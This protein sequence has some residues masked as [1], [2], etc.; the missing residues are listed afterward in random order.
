MHWKIS[1]DTDL[2]DTDRLGTT[3]KV[4]TDTTRKHNKHKD[5][6]MHKRHNKRQHMG[7]HADDNKT[8][9]TRATGFFSLL[10]R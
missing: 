3:N 1:Q 10:L 7:W 4:N 6:T 5:H 8:N 2:V 9:Q